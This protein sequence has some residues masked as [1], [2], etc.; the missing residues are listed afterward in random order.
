MSEN[1]IPKNVFGKFMHITDTQWKLPSKKSLVFFLG[2]GFCPYCATQRW[3]IVEALKNFGQWNNL[4]EERSASVEEKFVN[5]P[6]FSFAK[7]TFESELIEFIGRET[8]DRNFDPLQE[9][10]IDDQN[11]LDVYNPDNMIPFLLIDGQYMRFGSSIKPELL[12]NIGHD[13]VRNEISLEKSEIGK[14][15][16]EETKNITT[17][18]CKCVSDKS[19]ICK[20]MEIIEKRNEIN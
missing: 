3:A 18:I 4:V 20:S 5:V 15:I 7:A 19:D 6:T 1:F 13:T 9:L 17:L 2:A 10:N 16:R 8:A 12:Q 11:I 14:M